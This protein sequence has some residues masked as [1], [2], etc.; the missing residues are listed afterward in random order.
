LVF[1]SLN[2]FYGK[3][4]SS[5]FFQEFFLLS[6]VLIPVNMIKDY[7]IIQVLAPLT[8]LIDVVTL[9]GYVTHLRAVKKN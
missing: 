1:I 4:L 3:A 5:P 8:I 6:Q 2:T 7:T 9:I